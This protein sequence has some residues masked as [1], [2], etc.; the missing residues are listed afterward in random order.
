MLI[1]ASIAGHLNEPLEV[2]IS[3]HR[4]LTSLNCAS[5][6]GDYEMV[7]ALVSRGGSNVN[8]N[9]PKGCTPLMYAGR[10]G[11]SECVRYLLDKKASVLK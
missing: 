8:Q 3:D 4:G 5:I 9:S 7:R 11:Y 6:K 2:D 1:E 10:G